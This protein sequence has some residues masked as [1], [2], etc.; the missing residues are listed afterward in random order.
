MTGKEIVETLCYEFQC[1][2]TKVMMSRMFC[3]LCLADAIDAAIAAETA[4]CA[5]IVWEY[6]GKCVS[7]ESA[8]ALMEEVR[9]GR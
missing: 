8:R 4:R 6:R 1:P 9:R 5:E 2:H 7:D 3:K